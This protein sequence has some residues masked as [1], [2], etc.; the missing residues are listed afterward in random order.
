MTSRSWA[1]TTKYPVVT[2]MSDLKRGDIIVYDGDTYGHVG[3]YLGDGKMIDAS[4]T[5][6]KIRI[7]SSNIMTNSY[8]KSHFIK[9]CRVF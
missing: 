5:E 8:W 2:K 6:G 3:I 1:A 4:S 7:T 9:G